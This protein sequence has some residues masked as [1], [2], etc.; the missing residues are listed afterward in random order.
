M[1]YFH[2]VNFYKMNNGGTH[3]DWSRGGWGR[4]NVSFQKTQ[5]DW[6]DWSWRPHKNDGNH[7]GRWRNCGDTN[8]ENLPLF[9]CLE[10][11]VF[12]RGPSR[13]T[14]S[15][16]VL[17]TR[18]P[19]EN[20]ED[21]AE[22]S[23]ARLTSVTKT[24]QASRQDLFAEINSLQ[25]LVGQQKKRNVKPRECAETTDALLMTPSVVAYFKHWATTSLLNS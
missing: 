2:D 1:V 24:T 16:R 9:D 22:L 7:K 3:S 4:D 25:T 18:Y 15:L 8:D 17:E 6:S 20:R 11:S 13:R 23:E 14:Y 10:R 12:K 5:N 19:R 21:A